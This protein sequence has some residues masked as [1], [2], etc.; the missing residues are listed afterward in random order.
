MTKADDARGK[1]IRFIIALHFPPHE[2]V[3]RMFN[4]LKNLATSPPLQNFVACYVNYVQETW[5][6]S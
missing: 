5:L 1:Y 4:E 2:H 3:A 6:E